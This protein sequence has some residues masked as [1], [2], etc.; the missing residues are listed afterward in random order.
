MK[1]KKQGI[2]LSMI[3]TVLFTVGFAISGAMVY[4]TLHDAHT[5]KQG[6]E[7]LAQM[8]TQLPQAEAPTKGQPDE[9]EPAETGEAGETQA[10]E[11]EKVS[12]YAPLKKLNEDFFGWIN[13]EDTV[14]NYPVM[15]SPEEP[16]RYLHRDFEG[17]SSQS[18]VP[19]MDPACY[20]GCGNYLI[21]GHNMKNGSMFATLPSYASQDFREKHPLIH[22][23]TLSD[24]GVYEVVAAFYSQIYERETQ[25]VFRYY[26]YTDLSK[27]EDFESYVNQVKRAAVYDTGIDPEYG[28]QL[29]T[30][31]TCSYHT[32]NGRFVVV[33]RKVT[34]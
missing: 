19:F 17:N 5:E 10:V 28:D 15:H 34:E 18:G 21:Y 14:L 1:K 3:F 29:L 16:D 26:N 11:G 31:S 4:K 8:V 20:E 27:A 23:D 32:D 6:F 2:K 13:L 12:P 25:N 7:K 24:S 30:L 33:A 9:E 22:F